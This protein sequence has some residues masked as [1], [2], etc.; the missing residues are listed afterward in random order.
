MK[1][2][3]KHKDVSDLLTGAEIMAMIAAAKNDRDAALIAILYDSGC[4]IGELLSCK[5]KHVEFDAEECNITF[6]KSKTVAR[7][8]LLIF[9]KG[10]LE[11][12]LKRHPMRADKE[13]P[14]FVTE[15]MQN[16][17]TVEKPIRK[18]KVLKHD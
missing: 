14:L 4:R 1:F 9:A 16:I 13:A 6:P 3:V 5:V 17:G 7:T 10:Y 8:S 15:K 18:Y 2:E 11:T 12:Y